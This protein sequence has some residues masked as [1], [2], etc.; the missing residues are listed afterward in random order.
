VNLVEKKR[1]GI[2]N[3]KG[4]GD[5]GAATVTASDAEVTTLKQRG[6]SSPKKGA[7]RGRSGKEGVMQKKH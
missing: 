4:V 5:T 7:I 1:K 6:G 2:I 3:R